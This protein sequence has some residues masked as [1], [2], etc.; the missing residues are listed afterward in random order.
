MAVTLL[1]FPSVSQRL[2]M[3]VYS[4]LDTNNLHLSFTN[5]C[6]YYVNQTANAWCGHKYKEWSGLVLTVL[7]VN[8]NRLKKCI[9]HN[10]Y[11]L[12]AYIEIIRAGRDADVSSGQNTVESLAFR[13]QFI[14]Q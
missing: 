4:K 3:V 14:P 13:C 10:N 5:W 12:N 1:T 11:L 2:F 9:N 6:G 7:G 8:C